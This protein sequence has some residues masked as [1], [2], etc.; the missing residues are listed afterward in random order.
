M[1][2]I[3]ARV[4]RVR[5]L[6]HC[7]LVG[8]SLGARVALGL[9]A[10]WPQTIA[11]LTLIG[12][13]PGLVDADARRQRVAADQRL[14]DLLCAGGIEAFVERWQAHPIFASQ[15][16]LPTVI[17]ERQRQIRLAHRASALADSLR[18][19]GLGVMPDYR[20]E[21]ARLSMPV[22]LVTGALDDKFTALAQPLAASNPQTRH[23]VLADCGHNPLMEQPRA[24]ARVLEASRLAS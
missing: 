16:A 3:L 13:H 6:T 2:G 1:A 9:A 23:V 19:M 14:A 24:L 8:Y 15:E 22:T 18:H 4:L 7:H 17:R 11:R 10:R 21:F 12:V 20:S 5:E